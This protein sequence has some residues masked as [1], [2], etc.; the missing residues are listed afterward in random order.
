MHFLFVV[1]YSCF[2]VSLPVLLAMISLLMV[3]KIFSV[4]PLVNNWAVVAG[5]PAYMHGQE[6]QH[7]NHL[8]HLQQDCIPGQHCLICVSKKLQQWSLYE[9]IED[10]MP[11]VLNTKQLVWLLSYEENSFGCFLNKLKF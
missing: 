4:E 8:I 1:F 6:A 9:V 10:I 3:H 11:F 5:D 2:G 7:R